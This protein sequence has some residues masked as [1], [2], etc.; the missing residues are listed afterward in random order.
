MAGGSIEAGEC[1]CQCYSSTGSKDD[2]ALWQTLEFGPESV[3][4]ESTEG[5][6][7]PVIYDS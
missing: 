5:A 3:V 4:L 2:P 6:T 7:D 1:N